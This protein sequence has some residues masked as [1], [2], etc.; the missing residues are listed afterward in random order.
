M[1]IIHKSMTEGTGDW[2]QEQ[3]Y[4]QCK[5]QRDLSGIDIA[6]ESSEQSE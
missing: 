5:A 6:D 4:N 3:H 2:E 1:K